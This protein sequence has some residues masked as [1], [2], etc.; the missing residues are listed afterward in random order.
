M[1]LIQRIETLFLTHGHTLY[2]SRRAEAVTAQQHALQCAQ[3]AEWAGSTPALVAAALLHD[4]GHFVGSASDDDTD[5]AHEQRALGLL[6]L[7]FGRDMLEPIRLHVEAK[8]YLVATDRDYLAQ[9]SPASRHSLQLQ[10]GAM[11]LDEQRWFAS[12]PHAEEA[13]A[14]RRWDDAAKTPGQRTPPLSYY[15]AMVDTLRQRR[16]ASEALAYGPD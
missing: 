15:L 9:L 1:D 11:S 5:D 12:L 8:R 7:E 6:S 16:A 10:G 3:L 13:L 14:L 2:D 4:I